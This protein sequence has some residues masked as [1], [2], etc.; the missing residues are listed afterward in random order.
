MPYIKEHIRKSLD[1]SV[2]NLCAEIKAVS[3]TNDALC[4]NL[5][6]IIF[7]IIRELTDHNNG[8]QKNYARFNNILGALECCKLEIYSRMIS[9]YEDEKIKENG[10]VQW[11]F[12]ALF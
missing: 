1:N 3:N 7:K 5:N 8:G 6:Y 4:G 12:G 2:L 9:P 11:I 10:D